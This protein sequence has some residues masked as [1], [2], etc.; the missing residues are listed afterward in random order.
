MTTKQGVFCIVTSWSLIVG[1]SINKTATS[2]FTVAASSK[3]SISI[4]Q[5]MLWHIPEGSNLPS[6]YQWLKYPVT[7]CKLW[8][9]IN[10]LFCNCKS[11]LD[12]DLSIIKVRSNDCLFKCHPSSL[13]M[14]KQMLIS[15]WI[16]E[17]LLYNKLSEWRWKVTVKQPQYHYRLVYEWQH[18]ITTHTQ[19]VVTCH[20]A[21]RKDNHHAC[22]CHLHKHVELE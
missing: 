9:F 19:Y 5:T 7:E 17:E 2:F 15:A 11:L 6:D 14:A 10:L 21:I 13:K 12:F 22:I 20:T 1:S 16:I 8:L 4:Y 18:A 3:M